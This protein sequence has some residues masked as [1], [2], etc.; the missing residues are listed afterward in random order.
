MFKPETLVV[1]T[2]IVVSVAVTARNFFLEFI[3]RSFIFINFLK[4][5]NREKK[6]N[7]L[8]SYKDNIPKNCCSLRPLSMKDFGHQEYK[9]CLSDNL[10]WILSAFF[11]LKQPIN[12]DSLSTIFRYPLIRSKHREMQLR[13]VQVVMTAKNS[14]VLL[15][16]HII[17]VVGTK[18]LQIA[19]LTIFFSSYC[20]N[21]C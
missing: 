21:K 9:N 8:T 18:N 3:C 5:L 11:L 1:I 15:P 10:N 13:F 17:I 2:I 19:Y 14:L 4:I 20:S 12:N 16:N 7:W 6:K